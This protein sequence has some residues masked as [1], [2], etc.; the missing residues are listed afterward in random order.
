MI[1][2]FLLVT[3]CLAWLAFLSPAKAQNL[4]PALLRELNG[5]TPARQATPEQLQGLYDQAI[6]ALLISHDGKHDFA[7]A[8]A[9]IDLDSIYLHAS[10]PGAEP[11]RLAMSKAAMAL[12][13]PATPKESRVRLLQ[14]LGLIGRAES[15][16]ALRQCLADAD[17]DMRE[18]ARRALQNNPAT[19]ATT[20]L[21]ESLAQAKDAAWKTGLINA[22][23]YRRDAGSSQAF[24][25]ALASD[26]PT[27]A[28]AGAKAL[29]SIGG[30]AAI[31][32]LTNALKTS[33]GTLRPLVL[34]AYMRCAERLI[35][36][37]KN[38]Q[39]YAL[40]QTLNVPAESL[41]VRIGA[42][43]GMM[44]ASPAKAMPL[45]IAALK[46]PEPALRSAATGLVAEDAG[47]ERM[48]LILAQLSTAIP[49]VQVLLL[50]VVSSAGDASARAA[51]LPL[52]SNTNDRVRA[53]AFGAMGK[54]GNV[55]DVQLLA[56][57]ASDQAAVVAAAGQALV[58]LP[59]TGVNE[60]IVSALAQADARTKVL[61]I[62]ALASRRAASAL[63]A[64][65]A[66][67]MDADAPVSQAAVEALRAI[68]DEKSLAALVALY[69][70]VD[71]AQRL[72]IEQAIMRIADRISDAD[73]RFAPVG[74]A[75][76]SAKGPSRA[77]VLK[78][79]GV[80]RSDKA[81]AALREARNS[82]DADVQD[83]AIR[84]LADSPDL[85][86]APELLDIARNSR[87]D[88]HRILAVRGY[89]RLAG[90]MTGQPA[91]Q[92]GMYKQILVAAGTA[93]KKVAISAVRDVES[94]DALTFVASCV[95]DPDVQ[96]EAGMAAAS[97]G[98]RLARRRANANAVR[99]SLQKVLDSAPSDRVKAEVQRVLGTLR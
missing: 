39:A 45:L 53:A 72:P 74:A 34:D 51:V 43:R 79:A 18:T 37:K 31:T 70:K 13:A 6:K 73:A 57:A 50:N 59:G 2:R 56:K 86:A 5:K 64:L 93:E 38:D 36:D 96:E 99:A 58:R 15:V 66:A 78:L 41:M 44:A 1:R 47:P 81:I 67:L 33:A 68:G 29:G 9:L 80:I 4:D 11:E 91:E 52:T 90:T 26:D 10:R 98:E 71:A 88:R 14:I 60:A 83:A 3:V 61:L 27:L 19:E 87:N 25:D 12:L 55:G 46:A 42:L 85:K 69:V 35:A 7:S 89:I 48:Q 22:L 32:A 16:P 65:N 20:A 92:L 30:D 63:P 77:A 97:I 75:L 84:A 82:T 40:Y 23:G 8:Q 24:L 17:A 94:L 28:A 62:G 76:A 54:V 21:R 49:D 95:T